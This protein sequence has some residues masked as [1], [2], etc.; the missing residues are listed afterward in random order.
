MGQKRAIP[1]DVT[2]L[3]KAAAYRLNPGGPP[4]LIED[5]V[6]WA[7]MRDRLRRPAP[8]PVG[9]TPRQLDALKFITEFS[10]KHCYSPSYDQIKDAI[11]LKSKSGINRIVNGLVERG[12]LVR[13]S[14][15]RARAIAVVG[16][17]GVA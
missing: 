12:H 4:Y 14:Y 17:A 8:S 13:S 7:V 1:P 9:V 2:A 3:A 16:S 10:Q 15:C 11:G 6:A 5:V